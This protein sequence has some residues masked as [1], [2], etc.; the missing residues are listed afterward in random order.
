[1]TN[2]NVA[3]YSVAGNLV[4]VNSDGYIQT[5]ARFTSSGY[6]TFDVLAG[7]TSAAGVLPRIS[8]MLDGAN[9][10]AILE[11]ST[12]L[13]H[14]AV[15]LFVSAGAH[16]LGLAFLNDY[17][18][19]PEDRNAEFESLTILPQAAPR[20][21]AIETAP[22]G[23]AVTLQWQSVPG[24]TYAVQAAADLAP[25]NWQ[26]LTNFVCGGTMASWRDSGGSNAPPLSPVAPRR[27]YRVM[28]LGP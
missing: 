15:T 5:A 20:I 11:T 21:T 17:Y 25:L 12:N 2:V 1:M 27:F 6:Y 14:Y 22:A 9:Q 7:G 26:T 18:A 24:K 10:A 23:R 19:P 4:W 13:T 16:T 28:Q 3:A 8:V